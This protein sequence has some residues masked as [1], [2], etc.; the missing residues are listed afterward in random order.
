MKNP[1]RLVALVGTVLFLVTFTSGSTLQSEALP[2][3]PTNTVRR[4]TLVEQ[5]VYR[6]RVEARHQVTIVSKYKGFATVTALTPEGSQVKRGDVIARFDASELEREIVKLEEDYALVSSELNSLLNATIPMELGDLEMDLQKFSDAVAAEQQF[7]ADSRALALED[8]VSSLEV[9]QQRAKVAQLE[10][11]KAGIAQKLILTR[12]YLHPA[13]VQRA[14]ARVAAAQQALELANVQLANTTVVAPAGGIIVYKPLHIAG[15]YRTL[16]VGDTLHANQPFMLIPDMNDLVL[17]VLIPESE[18]PR[19]RPG[20]DAVMIPS[21]FPELQLRGVIDT[22][23][24][25]AETVPGKPA[26]QRFFSLRI[27]I[28]DKDAR[29]RPGMSVIAHVIARQIENTLLVSRRAV[30]WKNGKAFVRLSEADQL[31]EQKVV[32]GAADDTDYEV[33]SGL[34]EG[35]R[36][37]LR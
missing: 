17:R 14:E 27:S 18:L 23:G 16:R 8:I 25:V 26:W 4:G 13:R 21:A 28:D 35:S 1:H 7:L 20:L 37:A 11:E 24:A 31:F 3:E 22:I 32:L 12:D 5:T 33:I 19:V 2:D 10:A 15:E 34:S 30:Q 36:V 29:L 9:D 6:G